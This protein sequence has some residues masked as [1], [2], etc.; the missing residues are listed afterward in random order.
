MKKI[1]LGLLVNAVVAGAASA[2]EKAGRDFYIG[3]G[4]SLC[5]NESFIEMGVRL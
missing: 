4:F 1:V 5:L 2:Q 3:N